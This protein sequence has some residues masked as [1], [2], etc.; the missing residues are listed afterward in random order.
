MEKSDARSAKHMA[1][2]ALAVLCARMIR[3]CY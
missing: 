3:V 2:L 1:V